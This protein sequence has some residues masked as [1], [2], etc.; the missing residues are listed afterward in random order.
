M[1]RAVVTVNTKRNYV[2]HRDVW[3]PHDLIQDLLQIRFSS[4]TERNRL[5]KATCG[6]MGFI[7]EL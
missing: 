1:D 2:S 6:A 5:V 7:R 3:K 4:S